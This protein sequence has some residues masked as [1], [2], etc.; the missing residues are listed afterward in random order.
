[1]IRLKLI[2]PCYSRDE[3]NAW[4]NAAE[5]NCAATHF[6]MALCIEKAKGI[7]VVL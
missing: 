5:L 7:M 1:M 4:I 3:Q 6:T 2:K